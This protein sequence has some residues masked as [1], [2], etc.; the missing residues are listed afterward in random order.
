MR[1]NIVGEETGCY[2]IHFCNLFYNV[3][4]MLAP[5]LALL[6]F[7]LL[8]YQAGAGAYMDQSQYSFLA[9]PVG[10]MWGWGL[11]AMC[12]CLPCYWGLDLSSGTGR[13]LMNIKKGSGLADKIN[14]LR[15]TN[16]SIYC[17]GESWR[18]DT[19]HKTVYTDVYVGG[20]FSHTESNTVTEHVRVSTGT[21]LEYFE[22][23][24][25]VD[26]SN[27]LNDSLESHKLVKVSFTKCWFYGDP[28]TEQAWD[29][30]QKD[31]KRRNDISTHFEM[32]SH[33]DISGFESKILA[34]PDSS[35][36]LFWFN[37][38]TFYFTSCC[39]CCLWPWSCW[40]Q[41]ASVTSSYQVV[42]TIF[43]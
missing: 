12:C 28:H 39:C 15:S 35:K 19:I 11:I 43:A 8:M 9:T 22:Y 31:F 2:N 6:G 37:S 16:P 36:V 3:T 27:D 33:F 5:S 24:S 1:F 13:Y 41:Q 30:F 20:R 32:T 17:R 18:Y 23:S 42:K 40:L 25:C 14:A 38:P 21:Y 34:V 26:S 29:F 10:R 4:A 7:S